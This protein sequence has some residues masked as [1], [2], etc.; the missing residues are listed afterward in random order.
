MTDL[1][2]LAEVFDADDEI[3]HGANG[4][5]GKKKTEIS[6]ALLK[7]KESRKIKAKTKSLNLSKVER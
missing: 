2:F 3:T 4:K 1:V 6:P 5:S 7:A